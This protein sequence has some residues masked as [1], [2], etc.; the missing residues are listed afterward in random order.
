M[1][2]DKQKKL[3]KGIEP[4][5][6][7]LDTSEWSIR[8]LIRKGRIPHVKIGRRIYFDKEV[9]DRWIAKH[10]QKEISRGA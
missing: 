7:Y 9:I 6:K 4:L 5:A 2:S 1:E 8:N 10:S 3:I